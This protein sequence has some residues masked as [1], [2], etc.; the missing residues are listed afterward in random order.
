MIGFVKN[1]Q[2]CQ[3]ISPVITIVNETGLQKPSKI[4]LKWLDW[5]NFLQAKI[6]IVFSNRSIHSP[7]RQQWDINIFRFHNLVKKS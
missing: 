5:V 4:V 2:F 7:R 3:D 6:K 1:N